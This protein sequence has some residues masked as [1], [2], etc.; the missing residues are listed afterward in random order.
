[1]HLESDVAPEDMQIDSTDQVTVPDQTSLFRTTF[2]SLSRAFKQ[3]HR[4]VPN[5]NGLVMTRN[6]FLLKVNERV[7]VDVIWGQRGRGEGYWTG[8]LS[9]ISGRLLVEKLR[10][11]YHLTPIFGVQIGRIE[12]FECYNALVFYGDNGR[13]YYSPCEFNCPGGSE[14]YDQGW[15]VMNVHGGFTR[16]H[17]GVQNILDPAS[18]PTSIV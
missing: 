5:K 1:M 6:D 17:F 12:D 4:T 11:G 9:V 13:I 14:G 7:D 10:V 16:D 2:E 18:M 15:S 3:W 8:H